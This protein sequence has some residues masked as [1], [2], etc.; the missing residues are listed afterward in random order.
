MDLLM[1]AATELGNEMT[2]DEA[3]GPCHQNEIAVVH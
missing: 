2:A 3:A 1:T